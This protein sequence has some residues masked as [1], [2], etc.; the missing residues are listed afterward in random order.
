[1][2]RNLMVC[3]NNP[4]ILDFQDAVIGPITYDV[5]SLF[6]DAFISWDEEEI[7]DWA[8]RYWE[9]RAKSLCPSLPILESSTKT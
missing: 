8:V 1:M 2:P 4:G 7:I 5:V 3:N 9:K 6:K